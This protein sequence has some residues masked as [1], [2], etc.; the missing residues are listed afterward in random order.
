MSGDR[1]ARAQARIESAIRR[2]ETSAPRAPKSGPAADSAL[3]EKY[4]ALRGEAGRALAEIDQ[5][6]AQLA[7]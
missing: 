7:P 5:L 6:I 1:I 3:N 2:I 4:T